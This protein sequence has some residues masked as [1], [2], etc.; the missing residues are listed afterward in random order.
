MQY[1]LDIKLKRIYPTISLLSLL[2]MGHCAPTVMQTVLQLTHRE[3]EWLVKL[4]AGLPGGIGNTQGECGGVTS[5]LI[6]LGLHHGLEDMRD[7]LPVLFDLGHAYCQRFQAKNAALFCKE[8]QGKGCV[9]A[10]CTA[11]GLL[12][13]TLAAHN[14]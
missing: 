2:R 6:I 5:P 1:N 9:Q 8:I 10:I 3:Q 11:P 14:R 12:A 7:G 4:T 13:E